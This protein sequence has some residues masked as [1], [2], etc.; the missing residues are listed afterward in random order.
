MDHSPTVRRTGYARLGLLLLVCLACAGCEA[1]GFVT[2]VIAGPPKIKAKYVLEPR[3]TLVIV[4]DPDNMLG[5]PNN[6]A[7][8]GANVVFNLKE[9]EVLLPELVVSQD[10]L[11]LLAAQM[12]D[13]YMATPIDQIG[14]RLKAEQVIHVQV[15]STRMQ[16]DNTYYEPTAEVEVKVIDAITG[17]RLFPADDGSANP[18]SNAPGEPMTIQLKSQTLDETR[19]HALPMLARS[20]AERVGLEVAGL[21][22]DH[23]SHDDE[24]NG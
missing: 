5:D 1:P 16:S 19:R 24:P 15:R 21:F 20:L 2:Y 12:G 3:P 11:S 23:V 8:V 14:Q 9:N 10:H 18:N 22:Y 7:V 6:P 17:K 4:D 13:R